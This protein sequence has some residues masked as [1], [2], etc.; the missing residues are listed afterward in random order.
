M[1][2]NDSVDPPNNSANKK[3]AS[4]SSEWSEECKKMSTIF[5]RFHK[6]K[7][8]KKGSGAKKDLI[9]ILKKKFPH[10]HEK[11]IETFVTIRT[12]S[13]INSINIAVSSQKSGTL[14]GQKKTC[15][16]AH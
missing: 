1:V 2:A 5:N 4:A 11:I 10:R 6:K 8:F 3:V 13:R 14:R 15:Q 7:D 9:E 12:R 16:F